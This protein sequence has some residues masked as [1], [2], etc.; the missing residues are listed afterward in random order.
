MADA[1]RRP[2]RWDAPVL[3]VAAVR[4][5]TFR[6]SPML[7]ALDYTRTDGFP[8]PAHEV[9]AGMLAGLTELVARRRWRARAERASRELGA[10]VTH[11]ELMTASIYGD[12]TL[13]DGRQ[14]L[15]RRRSRSSS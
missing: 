6:Q 4:H 9:L 15:V 14:L 8:Q 10:D 1:S 12:F 7:L 13:R 3:A 5:T 11:A 2:E